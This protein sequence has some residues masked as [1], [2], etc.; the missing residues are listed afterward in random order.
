[1]QRVVVPDYG[2]PG[3]VPGQPLIVTRHY[4]RDKKLM[5]KINN[6]LTMLTLVISKGGTMRGKVLVVMV[7]L[8]AGFSF[9]FGQFSIH[10]GINLGLNMANISYSEDLP[11]EF[12]KTSR[13]G[14]NAGAALEVGLNE[15]MAVE[16]GLYYTMKGSKSSY[17]FMDEKHEYTT[18][19]D[20][21]VIP[22]KV[23]VK[24]SMPGLKPFVTVG[25]E[26]GFLLSAKSKNDEEIDIKDDIKSTDLGLDIGFG[27]ELP[28][29]DN[30]LVVNV[31]YNLGLMDIGDSENESDETAKNTGI[32]IL[33]GGK[34][35]TD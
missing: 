34:L 15:M 27:V 30:T 19:L 28:V 17:E 18:A 1:M 13:M 14:L 31:V 11:D 9:A 3:E 32:Y 24:F 4:T 12:D 21:L 35:G 16:S 6:Y 5:K 26:L 7:V 10:P 22:I 23:K 8:C 25:P 2:E 33:I 29:N 20:Y